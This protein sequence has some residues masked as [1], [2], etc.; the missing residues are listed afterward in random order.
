MSATP[1]DVSPTYPAAA[2][3]LY[4]YLHRELLKRS[5]PAEVRHY[6]QMNCFEGSVE[7]PAHEGY[8]LISFGASD[9][10]ADEVA[11]PVRVQILSGT[12]PA[13]AARLLRKALEA[14][15]T[16]AGRNH[17]DEDIPF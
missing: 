9:L 6:L 15:E 2:V 4:R 13:T 8:D 3:D 17:D 1:P 10:H 14:V 12:E 11:V 16:W 5:A 7:D